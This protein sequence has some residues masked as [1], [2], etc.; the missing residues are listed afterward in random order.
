MT[1][2]FPIMRLALGWGALWLHYLNRSSSK[3]HEPTVVLAVTILGA[4][5][6]ILKGETI[7]KSIQAVYFL[8]ILIL[9]R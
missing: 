9:H 7:E 8:N 6:I 1:S 3:M 2:V 5:A 4:L